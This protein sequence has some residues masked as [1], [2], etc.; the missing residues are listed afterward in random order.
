MPDRTL[1]QG[2]PRGG[3]VDGPDMKEGGWLM[4]SKTLYSDRNELEGLSYDCD[5]VPSGDTGLTR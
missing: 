2:S 1:M 4:S 5:R 3:I